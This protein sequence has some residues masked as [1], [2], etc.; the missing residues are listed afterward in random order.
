[1]YNIVIAS[2]LEDMRK[3]IKGFSYAFAGLAYAF[4][5]QLNFKVHILSTF[6]V[7]LAGYWFKLSSSEWLWIIAS[8]GVVLITELLNTAIETLVDLI[9]PEIH[10]KAKIIK[11]VAAGAVLIAAITAAGIGLVIFI[12]KILQYAA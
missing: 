12:P 1:M 2:N 11:D 4:K 10:P 3:F 5:S 6:L 9:S 8:I 7:S